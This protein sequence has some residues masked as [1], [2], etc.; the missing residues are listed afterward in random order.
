MGASPEWLTSLSLAAERWHSARVRDG[1]Q[2]P[3]PPTVGSG[4]SSIDLTGVKPVYA[5]RISSTLRRFITGCSAAIIGS[6]IA[7]AIQDRHDLVDVLWNLAPAVV[8]SILVLVLVVRPPAIAFSTRGVRI[9]SFL[10]FGPLVAWSEVV[11]IRVRG[12]WDEESSIRLP[13]QGHL[14]RRSLRGM[15]EEDARRLADVFARSR[16]P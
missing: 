1:G 5:L 6:A 10:R 12:R 2:K 13:I 15:P 4:T 9:R 16:E 8:G 11:D 3:T 7:R 14:R